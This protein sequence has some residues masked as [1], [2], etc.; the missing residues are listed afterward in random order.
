[1][2]PSEPDLIA[3]CKSNGS[4]QLIS[5]YGDKQPKVVQKSLDALCSKYYGN[6][7]D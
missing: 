5:K 6:G 1:M 4:V 7:D 2:S 3:L